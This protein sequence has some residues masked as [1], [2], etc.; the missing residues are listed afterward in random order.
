MKG[1]VDRPP[2]VSPAKRAKKSNS[3]KDQGGGS[4]I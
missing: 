1:V 2:A 3:V 4:V